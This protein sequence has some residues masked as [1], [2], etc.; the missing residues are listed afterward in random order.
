LTTVLSGGIDDIVFE[1]EDTQ[2]E[3]LHNYFFGAG[4]QFTDDDI[5]SLAGSLPVGKF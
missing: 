4:L 3:Y 2:R 5:K 1:P